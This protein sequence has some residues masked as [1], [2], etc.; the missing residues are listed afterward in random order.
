MENRLWYTKKAHKWEEALPVGNGR[1]GAMV[2]GNLKKERIALNEDTLWSGCPV[3]LNKKDAG[4]Y[5]EPLRQAIFEGDHEK[6]NKIANRDFHGHWSTN[7]LPFGDLIIEYEY[8]HNHHGY[9]RELNLETGVTKAENEVV[10]QSVFASHPAQLIVINIKSKK[11]EKITFR[12]RL[13]SQ[14]ESRSYIERQTLFL[15]GSAPQICMPPYYHTETP[16]DY[17]S[18]AMSFCGAVR[19]IGNAVFEEDCISFHKQTEVTLLLSMAT[20]FV[21]F[22]SMPNADSKQRA[23]SYFENAK[24]YNELLNEHIADF[25]ALFNRVEI[26]LTSDRSD[27]PTDKRIKH[28]QHHDDD[29]NLIALLFQYGRYLTLATSRKGTQASNLQGIFNEHLRPPWSSNYTVNINTEMNYWCTDI[30]NLSE[31]FEPFFEQ[32]KH[33]IE[34]GKTTARDYYNCSGACAHHNSDIWGMSRPAGDPLGKAHAQSYAYWQSSL[35]WMLNQ[36]FEHYRYTEDE[37]LF[38]EMKPCFKEVLDFYNDF[39][40]EKDGVM[41]TC[42]SSSPENTFIDEGVRGNLTYMPTMDIGILEEFFANCREFGFETP[43]TPPIPIGIDG[44]VLEWVKP[45]DEREIHHRHVSHLYCVYPSAMPQSEK[46]REAAK[47]SL[48]VR[49]FEGTGWALGWKVCL[50]ARLDEPENALHHIKNQLFPI[51]SLPKEISQH[52]GSY[53]N[54]FDAHPP[55]QI[56]GNFGVAAGIAEMFKRKSIPQSWSGYVKGIKLHGNRELSLEFENGRVTDEKITAV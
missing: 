43:D 18:G 27:L 13:K 49:G 55:F 42:P 40:I 48:Y 19:A 1:I 46:V 44:R 47:Q 56:D 10:C 12:V 37:K 17:G 16:I 14:L 28:F 39:L 2:F 21:D 35:P 36:V 26:D 20:G 34:T 32:V 22:K 52:G 31:C 25:S 23:L 29:N 3:D 24:P 5:L 4:E 33:M 7:Y 41:V 51:F 6:A 54:L 15:E 9:S 30:C 45:Y 38:E 50:W 11:D 8:G 53:A